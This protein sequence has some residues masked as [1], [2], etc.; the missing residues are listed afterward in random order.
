MPSPPAIVVSFA[1]SD[2]DATRRA[3]LS[4]RHL[5]EISAVK[6]ASA[7]AQR[8]R[9]IVS[10]PSG[11]DSGGIVLYYGDPR[12]PDGLVPAIW[13]SKPYRDANGNPMFSQE[14]FHAIGGGCNYY[15][16]PSGGWF[17][18]S[19]GT[20]CETWKA[21]ATDRIA[22]SYGLPAGRPFRG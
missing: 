17:Q 19:T 3:G 5:R 10:L 6:A 9:L 18:P 14:L 2:T 13:G 1:A 12:Y 8:A 11:A 21:S 4:A 7:P 20:G 15:Y 22:A 16:M